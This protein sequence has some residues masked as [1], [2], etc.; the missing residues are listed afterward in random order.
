MVAE[1]GLPWRY[2]ADGSVVLA[3]AKK[4]TREFGGKTYLLEESIF[5]DFG[6]VRAAKADRAGNLVFHEAA[7]NFNPLC[8]MAGRVA[9]A[10]AEEVVEIGEIAPD[11]IHLPGVFVHRVVAVPPGTE[12]TI[13]KA[14]PRP[15]AGG[16]R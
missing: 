12:K 10:E 11:D 16:E 8:A 14:P 7:R 4:E 9:I 3:S 15:A 1:G 13:E 5:C 6:L 2:G